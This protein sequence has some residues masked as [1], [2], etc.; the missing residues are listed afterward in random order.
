MEIGFWEYTKS[1]APLTLLTLL[2]GALLLEEGPRRDAVC[3]KKRAAASNGA[4]AQKV[5][6]TSIARNETA[7]AAQSGVRRKWTSYK[8]RSFRSGSSPTG[9]PAPSVP[10]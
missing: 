5:S 7:N 3:L 6:L 1:G 8:C 10:H 4:A 2:A 9:C